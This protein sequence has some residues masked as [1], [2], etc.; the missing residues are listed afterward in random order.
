MDEQDSAAPLPSQTS[1]GEPIV[2]A[3]DRDQH[4]RFLPG[5]SARRQSFQRGNA[6]K[7][8]GTLRRITKEVRSW[9]DAEF[10]RYASSVLAEILGTPATTI[11]ERELRLRCLEW[12][13]DRAYGRPPAFVGA[14]VKKGSIEPG[15]PEWE[16]LKLCNQRVPGEEGE[17]DGDAF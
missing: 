8:P 12:L 2:G 15:S 6:G 9:A 14:I 10:R 1:A 17:E 13:C 4:G 5:N 7:P 16:I 3:D 11:R